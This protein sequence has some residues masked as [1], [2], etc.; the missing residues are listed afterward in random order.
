MN[1]TPERKTETNTIAFL[2]P[3]D[4]VVCVVTLGFSNDGRAA[5][6]G[7]SGEAMPPSPSEIAYLVQQR[8]YLRAKLR[9]MNRWIKTAE[10]QQGGAA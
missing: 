10:K 9:R 6:M 1:K 7:R 5:F 3:L 8:E 2:P 4:A